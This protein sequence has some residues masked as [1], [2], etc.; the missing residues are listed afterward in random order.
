MTIFTVTPEFEEI[1]DFLIKKG[2][3]CEKQSRIIN[4]DAKPPHKKVSTFYLY[5][6]Y[7]CSKNITIGHHYG[8]DFV[9]MTRIGHVMVTIN[10]DEF[11]KMMIH[12]L[13]NE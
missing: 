1:H 6:E 5:N 7:K 2:F 11:H 8:R 12:F 13:K 10:M 9:Q 4:P 3:T